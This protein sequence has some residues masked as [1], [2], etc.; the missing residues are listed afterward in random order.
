M[1]RR[2]GLQKLRKNSNRK[3]RCNKFKMKMRRRMKR[4]RKSSL[5]Q[6]LMEN[7]V[8][9]KTPKKKSQKVYSI[10]KSPSGS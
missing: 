4:K 10:V 6:M 3:K 1:K 8:V 2:I 5:S 9:A 7:L